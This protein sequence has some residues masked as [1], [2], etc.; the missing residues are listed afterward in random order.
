MKGHKNENSTRLF[1]WT[2]RSLSAYA[3]FRSLAHNDY[4]PSWTMAAGW[5]CIQ[6]RGDGEEGRIAAR[7][8]LWSVLARL[9]LRVCRVVWHAAYSFVHGFRPS[10]P[11]SSIKSSPPPFSLQ[12][13]SSSCVYAGIP[14]RWSTRSVDAITWPVA[15]RLLDTVTHPTCNDEGKWNVS[16]GGTSCLCSTE[17]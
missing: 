2:E 13:P 6:H 17:M 11:Y 14:L 9:M 15:R 1:A 3:V 4:I 5:G 7:P 10:M 8:T 16:L 12:R